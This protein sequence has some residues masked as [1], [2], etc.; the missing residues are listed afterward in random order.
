MWSRNPKKV[1]RAERGGCI[2]EK[3]KGKKQK[4][5]KKKKQPKKKKTSKSKAKGSGDPE[6]DE[7][8]VKQYMEKMNRPFSVINIF[9]NLHGEIKKGPLE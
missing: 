7:I 6:K 1:V 5:G 2:K 8:R 3:K 9:D 4:D